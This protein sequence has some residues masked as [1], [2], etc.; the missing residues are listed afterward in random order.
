[1]PVRQPL[2]SAAAAV[3]GILGPRVA[4]QEV[5]AFEDVVEAVRR[6]EEVEFDVPD[7]PDS[8]GFLFQYGK[9]NWFSEPTFTIG[10]VRQLEMVDADG[11]HE[12]YSQVQLEFRYRVNVDLEAVEGRESWWFRSDP[13]SF[14]AWL[15]S[16]ESDPIWEIVRRK[17]PVEFDVSQDLA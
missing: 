1:V 9:V 6:F 13:M 5:P 2:D 3:R 12:A 17:V 14:D 10:F 15:D 8:D 4:G 11:E 7:I 16:V